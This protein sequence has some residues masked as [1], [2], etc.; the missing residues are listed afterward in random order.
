MAA[1]RQPS[2]IYSP[3]AFARPA[4]MV[5]VVVFTL[6]GETLGVVS[7]PSESSDRWR[8]PGATIADQ[9]SL[10]R[11]AI[12][13]AE[14]VSG[15]PIDRVTQIHTF[16]RLDDPSDRSI[17]VAYAAVAGAHRLRPPAE[18]TVLRLGAEP[19]LSLN[20]PQL[21]DAAGN[22]VTLAFDHS[23]IVSLAITRIREDLDSMAFWFLPPEFT[24]LELQ[25]VHEAV[26]GEPTNKDS[27]RR[28]VLTSGILQATGRREENVDH[29]PAELYRLRSG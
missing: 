27:F 10:D 8:L 5:E 19:R 2:Y 21:T 14:L 28:R 29:R 24:L 11:A 12:D 13:V 22:G 9:S 7:V 20:G 15:E 1:A 25:R 17:S 6:V 18:A 3:S 26:L 16:A 23:Q 4:V